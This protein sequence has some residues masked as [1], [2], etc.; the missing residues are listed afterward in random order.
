[1]KRCTDASA[2]P[3]YSRVKLEKGKF[4]DQKY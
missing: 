2:E 3:H 4:L 1:M